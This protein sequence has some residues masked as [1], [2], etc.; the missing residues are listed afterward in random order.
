MPLGQRQALLTAQRLVTEGVTCVLSSPLV[1]ALDT[2]SIIAE[3]GRVGPVEVW[4]EL[5]ELWDVAYRGYGRAALLRRFP[6]AIL[7][8]AV[9]DDGW[10]HGGDTPESV[11]ERC[12]GVLGRLGERSTNPQ[13][14][15]TE[16]ASISRVRLVPERDRRAWPPL[17]PAVEAAIMC[18]ND[19][20]HLSGRNGLSRE[21]EP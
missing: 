15:H 14:F 5:R 19:V 4:L 11:T 17:Y 18:L 20:S 3:T 9:T 12:Q 16:N 10:N 6:R 8:L 13:W 1:R 21:A 2:T 7:P